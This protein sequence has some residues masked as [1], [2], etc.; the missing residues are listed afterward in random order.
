MFFLEIFFSKKLKKKKIINFLWAENFFEK[1]FP[2]K[3]FFFKK[4]KFLFIGV[5]HFFSEKTHFFC[6]KLSV[7]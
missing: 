3:T 1:T 2:K 7:R 5:K 4:I 6:K